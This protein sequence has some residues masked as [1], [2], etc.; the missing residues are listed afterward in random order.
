[1]SL[2]RIPARV[3]GLFDTERHARS[4]R[5]VLAA[6]FHLPARERRTLDLTP[7]RQRSLPLAVA[8]SATLIE[9]SESA[10]RAC[11]SCAV[12]RRE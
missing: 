6:G 8:A 5:T 3:I 10:P 9:A 2:G 7:L 1:M 11:R 4:E 12:R